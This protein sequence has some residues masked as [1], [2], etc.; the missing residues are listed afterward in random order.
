MYGA[1]L[2]SSHF[3]YGKVGAINEWFSKEMSFYFVER[4]FLLNFALSY[5]VC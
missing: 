1:A 3:F 2:W 4:T 5:K